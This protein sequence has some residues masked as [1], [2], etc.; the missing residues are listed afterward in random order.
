MYTK[1]FSIYDEKHAICIL[2]LQLCSYLKQR[3][4]VQP[5]I[6]TAYQGKQTIQDNCKQAQKSVSFKLNQVY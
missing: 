4:I 1:P 3:K 5:D 2:L 6:V